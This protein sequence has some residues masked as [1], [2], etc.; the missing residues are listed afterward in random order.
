MIC[1]CFTGREGKGREGKERKGERCVF[2]V[3]NGVE[4]RGG[5]GESAREMIVNLA[6]LVIVKKKRLGLGLGLG[7]VVL[8]CVVFDSPSNLD[9]LCYQDMDHHMDHL[10]CRM[11]LS[12]LWE[13]LLT[14]IFLDPGR[15]ART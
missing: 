2:Y 14:C 7:C 9:A 15:E 12:A 4:T 11:V 5:E 13:L 8:C 6:N 3:G 1:E 10:I